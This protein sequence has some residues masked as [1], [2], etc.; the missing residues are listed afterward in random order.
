[1][2]SSVNGVRELSRGISMDKGL[3]AE[4]NTACEE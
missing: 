3:G 4:Q 2:S 1:M